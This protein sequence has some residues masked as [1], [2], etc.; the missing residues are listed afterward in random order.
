MAAVRENGHAL[1]YVKNKAP[2]I[3]LEA[4]KQNGWALQY[5]ARREQT[6]PIAIAALKQDPGC[7]EFLAAKF[8][9]P[10][11]YKAAG[12][13]YKPEDLAPSRR[14]TE[15]GRTEERH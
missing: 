3:C 15:H 14:S 8:R 10:E 12:Y 9:I 11:V 1:Y 2:D 7:R 13:N 6:L 5:I 4:V